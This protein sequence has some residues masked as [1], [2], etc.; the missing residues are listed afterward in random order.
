SKDKIQVFGFGGTDFTYVEGK[1]SVHFEEKDGFF[2]DTGRD[3]HSHS[4]MNTISGDSG[5]GW[6][7]E[8]GELVAVHW[9]NLNG[10]AYAVPLKSLRS[11]VKSQTKTKF[12]ELNKT[13]SDAPD[14]VTT[15]LTP[16]V[17][18]STS[19]FYCPTGH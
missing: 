4:R 10:T 14:L 9:G 2:L 6:F 17:T 1:L 19:P 13:L 8:K 12:P 18:Y 7:N 11:F 3:G 15:N 16:N 5:S